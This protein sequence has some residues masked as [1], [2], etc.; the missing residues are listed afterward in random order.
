MFQVNDTVK[1]SGVGSRPVLVRRR[2][3]LR[4]SSGRITATGTG[5]IEVEARRAWTGILNAAATNGKSVVLI[6]TAYAEGAEGGT[7]GVVFPYEIL[8]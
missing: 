1:L 5:Y 3:G 4:T 8:N 7:G 6:G 2:P